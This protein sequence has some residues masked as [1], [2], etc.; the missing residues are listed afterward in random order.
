MHF[1]ISVF[2]SICILSL[3]ILFTEVF[4]V[5]FKVVLALGGSATTGLSIAYLIRK[6]AEQTKWY[7]KPE[8]K[9]TF[10]IASICVLIIVIICSIVLKRRRDQKAAVA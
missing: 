10:I 5:W 6:I 1:V 4:P 8:L 2:V 3:V 9:S 7:A